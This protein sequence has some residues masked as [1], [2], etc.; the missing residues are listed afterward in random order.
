MIPVPRALAVTLDKLQ[1]C[2]DQLSQLMAA[3]PD[4]DLDIPQGGADTSVP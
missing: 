4:G 3:M 1:E 2:L